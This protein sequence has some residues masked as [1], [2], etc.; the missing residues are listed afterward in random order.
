[1]RSRED[2]MAMVRGV[3]EHPKADFLC[4]IGLE[5]SSP[6]QAAQRAQREGLSNEEEKLAKKV[7][8]FKRDYSE[9]WFLA[10]R[11]MLVEIELQEGR[12]S[13]MGLTEAQ[14]RVLE[15][16]KQE[17]IQEAVDVLTSRLT[18]DLFVTLNPAFDPQKVKE[19]HLRRF[20]FA[21]Q[22][23]VPFSKKIGNDQCEQLFGMDYKNTLECI[24][25]PE[26]GRENYLLVVNCLPLAKLMRFVIVDGRRGKCFLNQNKLE[27]VVEV[28]E[29]LFYWRYNIED[30]RL[31]L[32]K[33]PTDA[34]RMFKKQ[35][36]RRGLTA[37]ESL[38][39]AMFNLD[40]LKNHSIWAVGSRYDSVSVPDLFLGGGEPKL[41]WRSADYGYSRWGAASCLRRP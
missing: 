4:E 11:E 38:C 5:E 16:I 40:T 18:G 35:K 39:L 31:M 37:R 30:G 21:V 7:A 6:T 32:G 34:R 26:S 9:G 36:E 33:A 10:L 23:I 22:P 25:D 29:T 24:P 19:E 20:L 3:L 12:N 28:P 8:V 13:E 15:S 17:Y 2:L 14:K 27:D 1:M 41:N